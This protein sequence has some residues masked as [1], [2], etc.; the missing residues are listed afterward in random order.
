MWGPP[1]VTTPPSGLAVSL[2]RIKAE[3]RLD[4]TS[5]HD[6]RLGDYIAAATAHLEAM[7]G[8]RLLTQTLD[9]TCSDW[10]DLAHLPIAP[11]QSVTS[12]SYVDAA[13]S[14]ATVSSALYQA[15]LAALEPSIVLASGAAFPAAQAGS[16]ITAR[17]VVGY[18]AEA[19]IPAQIIQALRIL[20]RALNDDGVFDQVNDTVLALLA[21]HR[22]YLV[23]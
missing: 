20:V 22:L 5:S 10:A 23:S 17:L 1:V 2:D 12:I 9:V 16:L 11:V 21:N 19:A 18:G 15:R 4:G 6:T 14:A 8:L 7:S 3:L 13:G